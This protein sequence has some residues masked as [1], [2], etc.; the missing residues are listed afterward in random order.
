MREKWF[1]VMMTWLLLL[2]DTARGAEP[3]TRIDFDFVDAK[4][5]SVMEDWQVPG[6]IVLI[7]VDGEVIFSQAYG[8]SDISTHD[9]IDLDETIFRFASISKPVTAAAAMRLHQQGRLDLDTDVHHY[10]GDLRF[11]GTGTLTT[12]HLLTHTGGFEDRFLTRM[13]T[14]RW[15]VPELEAFLV[16]QMP[17]RVYA[18]GE[19]TLYSNHGMALAG[20]IVQ[21]IVEKPF[22]EAAHEL[23]FEPLGMANSSFELRPDHPNLAQG[24]R[25]GEPVRPAFINTVPSS[26]LSSTGADMAR[27]MTALLQPDEYDFLDHDTVDLML[28]RHFEHHST[29]TGRAYGFSETS[30]SSPRR[31]FHSGSLDGF[32]SGI[33]LLPER[34]G[35]ILVA[36]NGNSYVWP[37]INETLDR[38]FPPLSMTPVNS[39]S[40][41]E[42]APMDIAGISG[43][44]VPAEL[45]DRGFDKA[46]ALFEQI[47]VE[48]ASDGTLLHRDRHYEPL[49]DGAFGDEDG[50]IVI[51]R[52]RSSGDG[53]LLLEEGAVWRSIPWHGQRQLHLVVFGILSVALV[54]QLLG[55]P[56]LVPQY[57]LS[58][59]TSGRCLRLA[60]AILL[61]FLLGT[62][63]LIGITMSQGGG[64]LRFEIPWY[65]LLLLLLP[66]LALVVTVVAVLVEL[67]HHRG[68]ED[69]SLIPVTASSFIV[70][71]FVCFLAYW[72]LLGFNF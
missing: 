71:S 10:L 58:A 11:T 26:M 4:V 7:I 67:V 14:Q 17:R 3:T 34:S 16:E 70:L 22:A 25:F 51:Q 1:L 44:Y 56:L 6:A 72:R 41:Q 43:S 29:F 19:V 46:R 48:V 63:A 30:S 5:Q 69:N 33:V 64:V 37:L 55:R 32:S 40:S 45:P 47:K 12:A 13:S 31:L 42:F 2:A 24:Y 61:V 66:F 57:A 54:L 39:T 60:A 38:V 59:R 50:R 62:G 35:G 21:R 20:L 23:V 52:Q 36:L 15:Q 49:G 9:Q 8:F 28:T 68:S 18:A 65:L 53:W 27:F